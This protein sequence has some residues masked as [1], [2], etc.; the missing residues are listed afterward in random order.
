VVVFDVNDTDYHSNDGCADDDV[1][2]N[3]Q[4]PLEF[5]S[6]I[7][8]TCSSTGSLSTRTQRGRTL[9]EHTLRA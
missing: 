2:V 5:P 1:E 7:G 6:E 8:V 3:N 9:D 4:K